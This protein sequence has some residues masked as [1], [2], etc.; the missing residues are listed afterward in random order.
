MT[1]HIYYSLLHAL[2]HQNMKKHNLGTQNKVNGPTEINR[3]DES[4]KRKQI[5]MGSRWSEQRGGVELSRPQFK[6]V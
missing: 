5:P 6:S 3:A 4:P 1:P 2:I